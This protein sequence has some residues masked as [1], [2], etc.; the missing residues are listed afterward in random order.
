MLGP[1]CRYFKS[2]DDNKYISKRNFKLSLYD[3]R[4]YIYIYC[5]KLVYMSEY[6]K[7]TLVALHYLILIL[8]G[9]LPF[10]FNETV[11]TFPDE[12]FAFLYPCP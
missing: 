6:A 2:C 9:L 12:N 11:V 10:D 7:S 4:E 1:P 8:H 3:K 5:V